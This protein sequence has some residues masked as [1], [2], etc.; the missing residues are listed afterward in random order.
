[1]VRLGR[2]LLDLAQSA[3]KQALGR[4]V[5]FLSGTIS[6]VLTL[7]GILFVSVYLLANV[8]KIKVT[9]L[10]A[11][12][13]RYRRDAAGLWL[14]IVIQGAISSVGLFLLGVPYALLLGTWV[15]IAAIIPCLGA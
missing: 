10:M 9:F 14:D 1:M 4:L 12:P 6:V 15:A 5:G 7:F 2:D 8:R 13:K 3:V 11:A